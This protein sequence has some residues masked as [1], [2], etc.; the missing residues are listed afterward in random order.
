MAE[1]TA[2]ILKVIGLSITV[3]VV[4]S[5][6]IATAFGFLNARDDRHNA[7]NMLLQTHTGQIAANADKNRHQDA[8]LAKHDARMDA[9]EMRF[10][11]R[12]DA[13]EKTQISIQSDQRA[14]LAGQKEIKDIQAEELK[15]KIKMIEKFSELSGYLKTLEDITV[16][17]DK[18]E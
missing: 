4:A 7:Q 11:A 12:M 9:S 15:F 14:L 3:A 8:Q 2:T 16:T 10:D 13:T 17:P 18:P 5:G 1:K 6:G